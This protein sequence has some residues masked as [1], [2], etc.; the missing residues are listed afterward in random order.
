MLS[1]FRKDFYLLLELAGGGRVWGPPYAKVEPE[2]PGHLV[3]TE[4]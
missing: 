3:D 1:S 4:F 2:P